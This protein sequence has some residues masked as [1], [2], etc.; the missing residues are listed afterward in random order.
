MPDNPWT[1]PDYARPHD[2]GNGWSAPDYARPY[3]EPKEESNWFGDTWDFLTTP[4]SGGAIRRN[5]A[6][7]FAE[8]MY[9][10]GDRYPSVATPAYYGGA[11]AQGVGGVLDQSTSPLELGLMA[12]TGGASH[13]ASGARAA[14]KAGNLVKAGELAAT[15]RALDMPGRIASTGMVGHGA[16]RAATGDTTEEQLSGGLEAILGGLGMRSIAKYTL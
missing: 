8:F 15:A 4:L 3:E 16:Y 7:P 14:Q 2:S 1:P 11:F 5:V 10:M 6:D 13:F 12:T 9:G